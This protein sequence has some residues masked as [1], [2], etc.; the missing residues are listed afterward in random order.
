MPDL[1][2][3]VVGRVPLLEAK[4]DELSARLD[5]RFEHV[6]RR[7][8]AVDAAFLE[9][10]KHTEFIFMRLEATMNAGFESL[11]AEFRTLESSRFERK[12]DQVI[13]RKMSD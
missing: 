3:K 2:D 8:D 6:A 12:L 11:T 10:R 9:Q 4:L 5:A 1:P 13:D 7:F